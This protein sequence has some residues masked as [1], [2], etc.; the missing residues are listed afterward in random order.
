MSSI[1]QSKRRGSS[2]LDVIVGTSLLL[3]VF[4]GVLGA[5]QLTLA[6]VEGA[7]AKTGALA[8]A[9]ERIEYI[10]SLP[11]GSVGTI[12][13]IPQ[14]TLEGEETETLNGVTYTR[15][16]FVQYTDASEDGLGA[17]DSNGIT[18]DYKTVRVSVSWSFRENTR[19][20]FLITS[21]TPS[22]V[23]S[24]G[25]G[26]TLR[27]TVLDSVGSPIPSAE[28]SIVND[29]LVPQ[30]SLTT[31]TNTDGIIEFLA[32]PAGSGYE[33]SVEKTGYSASQ[34]YSVTGGNPNPN[35]GHLTVVDSQSTSATFFID[36]TALLTLESF[37]QGTTTPL[38]NIALSIHGDRTIGTDED[39]N[40]IYKYD[41]S[42]NT[43]SSGSITL[44]AIEW[45]NYTITVNGAIVGYDISEVCPQNPPSVSP[46]EN[47][48]VELSF[49]PHTAHSLLVD[50]VSDS[51]IPL[52]GASVR[53]HRSSFDTTQTTSS[54]GATHFGS[55]S[56]GTV[57][58]GNPYSLDVSLSGYQSRTFTTVEASGSSRFSVVLNPL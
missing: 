42:T 41:M 9:N 16:T 27:I 51:G 10:R 48:T 25:G 43:G 19:T 11:Y 38:A 29:S 40:P 4:M 3:V 31:F 32:A 55:L 44:A 53:L 17:L 37:P 20:L 5:L 23:E 47:K 7:K 6:L 18:T 52:E 39:D 56:E 45:D 49:V 14:G 46:G 8:L 57:S 12:G 1:L 28:V 33:I 21:I 54:C 30:V 24:S 50:V 36:R 22:G 13:G 58:G 35:P 15:R 2:F 26:G 34:T